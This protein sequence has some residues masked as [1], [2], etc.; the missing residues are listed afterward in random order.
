MDKG[1]NNGGITVTKSEEVKK[2]ETEK[3]KAK[4]TR[5]KKKKIKLRSG[6]SI[7]DGSSVQMPFLAP[8]KGDPITY[9]EYTWNTIE[10]GAEIT[11]GLAVSGHGKLGVPTLKD[12]KVLRALQDIYVWSKIKNGVLELETDPEKIKEE[13]LIIDFSSVDDVARVMGKKTISGQQRKA[14]KN[15]IEI[16]VATTIKST[17][18]G[19]LYDPITKKYITNSNITYRY[20]DA[21][22]DYE[23]YDCDNCLYINGCQKDF[24]N[25]IN[26]E[27]KKN[28][29]TRIRISKYLYLNIA[30]NFRLYYDRDNV[31]SIKN[32]MAE[33][34]Y[35]ISR[36]WLGDGYISKAHIQKYIDRLH[37]NAKQDKHKKQ[38]VKEGVQKLDKYEF[39]EA[40]VDDK[41]IV[42]V[43]HLDKMPTKK[44][45]LNSTDK[46]P[47]QDTTHMK[48]KF[49]TFADLKSGMYDIG[50]TENEFD[51][52]IDAYMQKIEYIKAL[53]RYVSMKS[54]YDKKINQK[55]YFVN[56][57]NKE[58]ELDPKYFSSIE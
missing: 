20:I 51:H 13:D 45:L 52:I 36:K 11:R 10:N 16:L 47:T 27:N 41:D 29:V 35:M 40:S 39:V 33:N 44:I 23:E 32:L 43:V 30:N 6:E 14:I 28:N 37:M 5:G 57:L 17:H 4:I 25:C 2:V 26:E 18:K 9:V 55:E 31:N 7:M 24:K 3:I 12:K 56:C 38:A 34:I 54:V 19:G 49:V 15:S 53:L 46:I 58:I 1:V 8:Y 50:F 42:T 22:G 21:M 48:D